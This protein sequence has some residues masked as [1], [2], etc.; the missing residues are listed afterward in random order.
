MEVLAQLVR[1]TDCG[2]VG[3]GFEPHIPPQKLN[4]AELSFFV[5]S[6]L[7]LLI[8]LLSKRFKNLL[9]LPYLPNILFIN[10]TKYATFRF[11][12]T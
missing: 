6:R 10:Q 8:H 11:V 2:S 4:S 1:A 9:F 12:F 7:A 3:R 5:I